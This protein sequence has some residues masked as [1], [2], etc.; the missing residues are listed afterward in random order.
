MAFR[1]IGFDIDGTL[2]PSWRLSLALTG[3]ALRNRRCLKAFCEVRMRIRRLAR[4]PEYRAAPP[5]GVDNFHRF[6]AGLVA[7]SMGIDEESALRQVE[8]FFYQAVPERFGRIRPFP[9]IRAALRRLRAAGLRLGALSDFPGD[10]KLELLGLADLFD[11]IMTSE[12]TGFLKPE[13]EPIRRLAGRLGAET[14]ELL[15]VGNTA[16]LDIAAARAA[17]AAAACLCAPF[18][19]SRGADFSFRRYDELADWILSRP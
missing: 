19:G 10:R 16:A 11:V 3:P 8:E 14:P 18:R 2:Y 6:Q 9:G 5:A 1:A 17:G 7:R 15:Y 13:P 12:E 4:T